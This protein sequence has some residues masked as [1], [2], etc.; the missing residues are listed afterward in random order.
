[1]VQTLQA[2]NVTLGEL[3]DRLGNK[4]KIPQIE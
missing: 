2:K 1:M 3:S 4:W